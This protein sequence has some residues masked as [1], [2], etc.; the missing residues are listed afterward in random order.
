MNTS[1]SL[2]NPCL[3]LQWDALIPQRDAGAFFFSTAWAQVLVQSYGFK[4][5]YYYRNDAGQVKAIVPI[6]ETRTLAGK[7][8]GVS[9]PFT[10]YC[11][12]YLTNSMS[13]Q[14]VLSDLQAL[15]RNQRWERIV[16]QGVQSTLFD[17]LTSLYTTEHRHTLELSNGY[18][19]IYK[20]FRDS[21]RR[22]IHKAQAHSVT[23]S[24]GTSMEFLAQFYR[25]NCM[26]R[27]RH[28]LPPQP[29]YFFKNVFDHVLAADKGRIFLAFYQKKCIAAAVYFFLKPHVVYKYGASDSAFNDL[30]A[31]NFVM[32]EAI[33]YFCLNGFQHFC[34]GKTE[35]GN[36]GLL[37][38]KQGFRPQESVLRTYVFD[39]TQSRFITQRPKV[40]TFQHALFKLLP[41]P[42]LRIAGS[43]LYKY[44]A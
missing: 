13:I 11:Q 32:A 25:L 28:G 36:S 42:L 26:T 41:I 29:F 17:E 33:K 7:R 16:F 6:M 9:L 43:L 15:G 8:R 1:G 3:N 19:T 38:Y 40:S 2:I 23:V 24:D 34:F 39:C 20:N 4:P 22:N 44:A 21:N 27:K 5:C 14:E 18:E 30:R 35:A 31:N 37:Q 12:P 10:D